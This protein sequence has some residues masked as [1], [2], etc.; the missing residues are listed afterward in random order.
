M[1]GPEVLTL[2]EMANTYARVFHKQRAIHTHTM[3]GEYFDAFRSDEKL[4]P[5]RAVGRITWA[6]FLQ[7]RAEQHAA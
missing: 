6:R 7:Q 1:G 2:A 5:E 3:P 4:V